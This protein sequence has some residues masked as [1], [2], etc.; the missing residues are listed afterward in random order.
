MIRTITEADITDAVVRMDANMGTIPQD[1]HMAKYAELLP[2]ARAVVPRTISTAIYTA[3]RD[4]EDG[5]IAG[6][7][8]YSSGSN[9]WTA[10]QALRTLQAFLPPG[11]PSRSRRSMWAAPPAS[12]WTAENQSVQSC[13]AGA[14]PSPR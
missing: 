10:M 11:L 4:S 2:L 5:F 3:A 13:C 9:V 12:P 8:G 1:P 6:V 14:P 7:A